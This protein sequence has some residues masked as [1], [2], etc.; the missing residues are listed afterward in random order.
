MCVWVGL[1]CVGGVGGGE[2]SRVFVPI[3]CASTAAAVGW[4][5]PVPGRDE[6][7]WLSG[8]IWYSLGWSY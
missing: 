1:G 8:G 7:G 6:D 5:F 2:C 3:G 4:F